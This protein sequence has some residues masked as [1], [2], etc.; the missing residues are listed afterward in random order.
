MIKVL[1][2]RE[3]GDATGPAVEIMGYLFL[4]TTQVTGVAPYGN[5]P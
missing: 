4:S 5:V 1:Y 2:R 3:I